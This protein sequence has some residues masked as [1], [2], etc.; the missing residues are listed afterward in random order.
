MK[1]WTIT[2]SNR[3]KYLLLCGPFRPN[4]SVLFRGKRMI[5]RKW[6]EIERDRINRDLN[7]MAYI[8]HIRGYSLDG[9]WIG[10]FVNVPLDGD[11][12]DQY[13]YYEPSEYADYGKRS[14]N[15]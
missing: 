12:T 1:S 9:D 8:D 14:D 6:M 3:D 15:L 10:L 11:F 4:Y 5:N 13:I 2:D 7:R